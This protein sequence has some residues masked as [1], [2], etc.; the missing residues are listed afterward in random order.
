MN[1][2]LSPDAIIL[3]SPK[4]IHGFGLGLRIAAGLPFE[5]SF[6]PKAEGSAANI[7]WWVIVVN[8]RANFIKTCTIWLRRV[9][10]S[11]GIWGGRGLNVSISGWGSTFLK[12]YDFWRGLGMES[13]AWAD[14][15]WK[16]KLRT[17]LTRMYWRPRKQAI[18]K[19]SFYD[20]NNIIKWED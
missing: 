12:P 14:L 13:R 3:L 4:F 16:L 6:L 2:L 20:V 11:V 9:A 15:D 1:C 7:C 5:G 17:E 19:N 8:Y 10:C 18:V